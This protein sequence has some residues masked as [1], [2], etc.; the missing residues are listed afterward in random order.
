MMQI[1]VEL[2]EAAIIEGA[3]FGQRFR[4]IIFKLSKGGFMSGFM[5]IF[6]TIMKEL[7]LIVILMTPKMAT[8]PYM[9]YSYASQGFDQFSNAVA[10]IMF[11]IVFI[12]YFFA[13][14]FTNADISKGFGG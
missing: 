5:L 1:G 8:L 12:V 11:V 10:V 14:K 6:I 2:E 13:N 4:K 7:D 3:S 9:A